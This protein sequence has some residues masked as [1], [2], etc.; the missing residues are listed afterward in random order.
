MRTL[1]A[2]PAA[3]LKGFSEWQTLL[4]LLWL[5]LLCAGIV[6]LPDL[7]ALF[8]YYG[9]APLAEGKPLL[10]RE[11]LLGIGQAF[12]PGGNPLSASRWPSSSAFP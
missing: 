6:V 3:L 2:I 8:K 1:R 12:P 11:L 9:H 7:G 10:S 4:V 5:S